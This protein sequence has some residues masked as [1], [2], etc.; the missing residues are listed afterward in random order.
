MKLSFWTLGMPS[1]PNTEVATRAS[2]LG[3]DGVDLRCTSNNGN[4]SVNSSDEELQIIRRVF[5][6][7]GVELSCLLGYNRGG[8]DGEKV[9][10][11]VVEAELIDLAGVAGKLGCS[12][13]RVQVTRPAQSW[14]WNWNDY[15]DK[16]GA[17]SLAAVKRT[18]GLTAVFENHV[19]SASAL[20]LLQMVEAKGD[21]RLG[22]VFSPDHCVVMQEDSVELAD[23]YAAAISQVCLADR[24]AV[25]ENLGAFDGRYYY[26]RYETCLMGEGL[27]PTSKIL[28]TLARKGYDGYVALKWEKSDSFG[29][30]LPDGGTALR[31]YIDY[32]RGLGFAKS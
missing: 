18:P 29:Q 11:D 31:H 13:M 19:G 23:R 14:T 26:V 28:D 21:D 2:S 5:A 4:L 24:R 1:W 30:H 32:M 17:A 8:H 3:Y 25:E 27:V 22:V 20:Q 15:L 6:E 10:W 16:L 12:Q 7:V 9:D